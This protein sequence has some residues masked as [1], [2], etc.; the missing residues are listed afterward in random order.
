MKNSNWS[1]LLAVLL[2]SAGLAVA[3]TAP[4]LESETLSLAMPDAGEEG[5]TVSSAVCLSVYLFTYVLAVCFCSVTA[6]VVKAF[7]SPTVIHI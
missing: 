5:P 1:C 3:T 4:S 6:T 2:A 7:K